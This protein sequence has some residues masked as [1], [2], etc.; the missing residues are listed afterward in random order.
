MNKFEDVED[1]KKGCMTVLFAC[2]FFFVAFC[3]IHWIA[4]VIYKYIF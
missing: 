1:F 2:I 3:L 4:D